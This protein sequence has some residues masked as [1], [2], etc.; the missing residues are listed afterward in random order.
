MRQVRPLISRCRLWLTLLLCLALLLSGPFLRSAAADPS[1]GLEDWLTALN[2]SAN[3]YV[4]ALGTPGEHDSARQFRTE[5]ERYGRDRLLKQIREADLGANEK[6]LMDFIS[7]RRHL[8]DL[9]QDNWDEMAQRYGGDPRFDAQSVSLSRYLAA[10]PCDPTAPDHLN[11]TEET[12]ETL[13][14]RLADGLQEIVDIAAALT[15]KE[16]EPPPLD[17]TNFDEFRPAR[18][19]ASRQPP[20]VVPLSPSGNVAFVLGL[21]T[22]ITAISA[23]FW[24]R[25]SIVQR[26]AIR[27]PCALPVVIFDGL[28]PVIGELL[29]ISQ[30][31]CKIESSHELHER[32]KVRLTCGPL[33]RKA[34]VIWRN[35]HFLGLQ[36]DRQ[37]TEAEFKALLG[38]HAAQIAAERADALAFAA[39]PRQAD[40][41][42][43]AV[44]SAPAPD[45]A[46]ENDVLPAPASEPPPDLAA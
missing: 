6:P 37:L 10:T 3:S 19:V 1:C 31:G 42:P 15:R 13:T 26:R 16:V 27:Y 12:E 45:P 8:L 38:P 25:Y 7:S 2:D 29:D 34:R 9:Q 24:M 32:Q 18:Q 44:A 17:P 21:F 43:A 35:N 23:W 28:L 30:V 22:F 5:M 14:T 40:P 39:L 46:K 11:A 4:S 36:F 33:D 41:V 20:P